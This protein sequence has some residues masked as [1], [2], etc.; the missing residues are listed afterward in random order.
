MEITQGAKIGCLVMAAGNAARFRSNKLLAELNGK[1]VIRYALEAVPKAYF[2]RVVVVT[3]YLEVETI[4][5]EF[6]FETLRNDQPEAGISR[7]IRLGTEAMRDCSA[8]LYMVAD[9]P[10]LDDASIVRILGTWLAHPDSI[11]GAAHNGKRGNPNIFP[12]AF[13]DELCA[14]EGDH[15]GNCIIFRHA[16]RLRLVEVDPRELQDIDTPQVLEA[17]RKE[18][19]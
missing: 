12:K 3:Q 5:R 17:L 13:F 19:E 4:A 7:T 16:D 15:G 10:L 1:P 14:L 11:V 6:G 8:I 2:H 9:Q 18:A